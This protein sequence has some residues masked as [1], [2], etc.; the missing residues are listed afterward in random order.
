VVA[1]RNLAGVST[2]RVEKAVEQLGVESIS[3]SQV[4][5]L[6]GELDELVESFRTHWTHR[7]TRFSCSTGSWSRCVNAAVVHPP[8]STARDTARGWDCRKAHVLPHR[9]QPLPRR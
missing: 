6:A 1:Y 2:R 4:S 3:K 7:P 9:E 8:R 5:R